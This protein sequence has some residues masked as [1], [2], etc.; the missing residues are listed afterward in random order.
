MSGQPGICHQRRMYG[1][2]GDLQRKN[3]FLRNSDEYLLILFLKS[4]AA[5]IPFPLYL[6]M[7]EGP[8][9]MPTGQQ[10]LGVPKVRPIKSRE[11]R[12]LDT[13]EV[14][15]IHHIV[16]QLED[17]PSSSTSPNA[18]IFR[19]YSLVLSSPIA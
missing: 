12:R 4:T 1:S 2:L 3:S 17:S 8:V 15:N 18:R 6:E 19:G 7:V 9:G 5:R 11:G 14:Q 10:R 13:L 16:S